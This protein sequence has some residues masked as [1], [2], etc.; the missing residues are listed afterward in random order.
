MKQTTAGLLVLLSLFLLSS[1]GAG[2]RVT[3][4]LAWKHQFQFAGYYA[5]LHQGYYREAGIEAVI[6]E[7]G[8]GRFAR[9]EVLAG[10]ADFG[11]AGAELLLHRWDGNP[12]VVMAPI[13]QHSPS[14]LLV[15]KDSGITH[16]Q[17]LIGKRVMLLPGK[18][19][20]DILAA[21]L[22]E[23]IPLEAFFRLD[24]TYN[25]DDLIRGRTDAVSSYVTNEPYLLDRQGVT[26]GIISPRT[27]GVDFYS[28]C[29]FTSEKEIQRRPERA[30]AFLNASL[31][32]WEFAMAHPEETADLIIREYRSGKS[33]AHLLF[34]AEAIRKLMLP[35]L[36][37]IGHMNPGRWQHIL[38]T[39]AD[40]GM[41]DPSFDIRGL[42]YRPAPETDHSLLKKLVIS[43]VC[44]C[45]LL[46]LGAMF[47]YRFNRK[48]ALEVTERKQAEQHL[49]A[50]EERFE[51][52]MSHTSDGLYD[53]DLE[54][55]AI[56]YSPG[57]KRMLGYDDPELDNKVSTWERL[58]GPDDVKACREMLQQ[59]IDGDIPR[60]EIE[61]KMRHKNGHWVDILS[62]ANVIF[63]SDGTPKRV[64]GTHVDISEQ[65]A[66][67][68]ALL[69]QKN[70][71]E[72]YLNLAPVMF[73]GLDRHGHV[74]LANR[75]ACAILEY[76]HDQIIGR[77]WFSDFI[78]RS[79]RQDV[80]KV[81]RQLI[82]GEAEPVKYYENFVLSKSGREISVAW[83]NAYLS[84][85]RGK[86]TGILS[87][88][89]DI[90]EKRQLETRL[91]NARKM[92]SIG[93][94][95]GGIAHEF[96]NILS[97]IIGNN[98]LIMDDLPADGGAREC[99]QEIQI[100][101]RRARDVVRQLLTFSR[102][103]SVARS[104]M[105]IR[106]TL[107]ESV[108]LI[109][110]SIP[111]NIHILKNFPPELPAIKGDSAQISQLMLNL[112]NNAADAMMKTGGQLTITL[113]EVRL[114][115]DDSSRYPT[116]GPGPYVRLTVED[117]GRGIDKAI[118]PRIFDPYFTTK[119][120]GQGSGIGLAV[121]H[122]IVER[123]SGAVTVDSKPEK[124]TCVT[125]L[126]PAQKKS[127]PEALRPASLPPGNARIL[128]V[129]D[130]PAIVK[131][132]RRL[133]TGLG[134]T[135]SA[136]TSPVE[137]LKTFSAA[138]EAFDLVVSDMAMP[139]M[140]G[141][142]LITRLREIRPD[143]PAVICTGY[144]LMM[145][146]KKADRMGINTFVMK[147][148][149]KEELSAAVQQALNRTSGAAGPSG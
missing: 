109:R 86:I 105:D 31:R 128:F 93:I 118:L 29:L 73:I 6:V 135:V 33:K 18:K 62:R 137:A 61:F 147:P 138:P 76:S 42:L 92:E 108:R 40:L 56:Y 91:F 82:A 146:E 69:R 24:Q 116:L 74:N 8:D 50:S 79:S 95:A 122:G 115:P 102:Q 120:V 21:F 129:D 64:V 99:A 127:D 35:D 134:Y 12:F 32:G 136:F 30:A 28:D 63:T 49:K 85:D 80:L 9:E 133:L 78:C 48:L 22:N 104:I 10:R 113:S 88:G 87:S 130:E 125:I 149:N 39:Y 140:T 81:F 26:P 17:D 1:A 38:D 65:K 43:T 131:F 124:G 89:E 15:R 110:A 41:I 121:V 103:D 132:S 101:G 126:F 59:V 111:A 20:A 45:V 114:A 57:W 72:T 139:E 67:E 34:E 143:V 23:G 44:V 51:L 25:P 2:D 46:G 119:E 5:A 54:T 60:F 68:R 13:F 71:A 11:V 148:L 4:Q 66:I 70:R 83:H 142:R 97:I 123:H 106:D 75:K 141:D 84:D 144:S 37:Q 3:L 16:L 7:G 107:E 77:N 14:A 96:N 117:T 100:A 52:A 98:E 94:L 58:T 47:L 90:S 112:C 19:D 53:W 36:V 27:Y 145:S 55:D